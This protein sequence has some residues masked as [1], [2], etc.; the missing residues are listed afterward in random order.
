MVTAP[1]SG[2]ASERYRGDWIIE[3]EGACLFQTKHADGGDV[4]RYRSN[5]KKRLARDWRPERQLGVAVAPEHLWMSGAN[6]GDGYAGEEISFRALC[7]LG[8]QLGW[9][10]CGRPVVVL[11]PCGREPW[12]QLPL[13]QGA[14]FSA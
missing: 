11:S 9:E 5:G 10:S 12:S 3:I 8:R 6:D 7:P 2:G 4:L 1:Q 14:F 13:P